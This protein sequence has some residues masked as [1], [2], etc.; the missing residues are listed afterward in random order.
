MFQSVLLDVLWI[1]GSF[2]K[3]IRALEWRTE[4]VYLRFLEEACEIWFAGNIFVYCRIENN[5]FRCAK[6]I[7]LRKKQFPNC[8][9]DGGEFH[10]VLRSFAA[11]Y[12]GLNHVTILDNDQYSSAAV[13]RLVRGHILLTANSNLFYCYTNVLFLEHALSLFA[14]DA[15]WRS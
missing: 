5:V 3:V 11:V 10:A 13:L 12:R 14:T 4:E 6:M 7:V 1:V 9:P 8:S 15:Q 2:I